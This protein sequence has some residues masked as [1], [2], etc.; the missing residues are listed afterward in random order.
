VPSGNGPGRGTIGLSPEVLAYY[1]GIGKQI[2][3]VLG[4]HPTR[5]L[6]FTGAVAGD[7][8]STVVAHLGE[9]LARRGEKV[10][11]ID[12]NAR[13]PS[14]HQH[15]G[16]P[17]RPGLA[18]FLTGE[19]SREAVVHPTGFEH[20]SLVP[21]GNCKNRAE[22]DRITEAVAE[23]PSAFAEEFD[24]VLMDTDYIG[25]PFFSQAA[26]A[27]CDGVILVIRAGRTNRQVAGRAC[28]T[29]QRIGGR[30]LGV[31][32]NRRQFPI[33]SFLYRRL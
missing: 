16:L 13:H 17:V 15:F 30:I 14:L 2:E 24:Y 1:E 19:V 33:P 18:E 7:G 29:V 28:E 26:V 5:R 8:I 6:V 32:L 9:M 25:S 21:L 31:V 12:A 11:L 4:E 20:L 10:L 27:A 3:V 23:F 22:A